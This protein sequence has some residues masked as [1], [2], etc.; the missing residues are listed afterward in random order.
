MKVPGFRWRDASK[1]ERWASRCIEGT[2]YTFDHLHDFDMTLSRPARPGLGAM[3]VTIRVVFDCHVV[4]EADA[5]AT[6]DPS[7]LGAW[8]DSGGRVRRFNHGRYIRSLRLPLL[9][10]DLT[11][12]NGRCYIA[13][14]HNFMVCERTGPDSRVEYYHVYFD[15]YRPAGGARL[16]MYVQSAYVKDQPGATSRRHVK[17]FATLCA[18]KMGL[19]PGRRAGSKKAP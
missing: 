1:W 13:S 3:T 5:S 9:I 7:D 17:Q 19:V 12:G 6:F 11:S 18:E 4:T 2:H 15:L 14:H 8:R 16:V 10:R